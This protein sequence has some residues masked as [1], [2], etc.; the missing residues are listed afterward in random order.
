ML[1]RLQIQNYR[2]IRDKDVALRPF[3]VLIGPNGSGK[4]TFS[5]PLSN[6][7]VF[8]KFSNPSPGIPSYE[9]GL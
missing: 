8:P 5:S 2:S 3:Q 9:K 6:Y 1:T 4:S 7:S